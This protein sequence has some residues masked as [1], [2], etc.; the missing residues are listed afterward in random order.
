M[1]FVKP[2][3]VFPRIAL[4]LALAGLSCATPSPEPTKPVASADIQ[5]FAA[6]DAVAQAAV[7]QARLVELGTWVA[8][9]IE[10]PRYRVPYSQT[11]LWHGAEQG[12]LVT[13]V[14]FLDYQCP[15]SQRLGEAL[16]Q[17]VETYPHELRVVVKQLPLAKMHPR[18]QIA[19]QAVLA[20][21]AQG[22][23]WAMHERVFVSQDALS[24]EDLMRHARQA[25]VAD[26]P[27]FWADVEQAAASSTIEADLTLADQLGVTSTPSYFVNGV[28]HRGAKTFLELRE[29]YVA[30]RDRVEGL[31]E[32]GA[33]DDEVYAALMLD[34]EATREP[35]KRA[36]TAPK[37]GKPDPSLS[38]A[39]PVDHR[40]TRGRDDALVTIIEFADFDCPYSRRVQPTLKELERRYGADL[41][42]VYRHQPLPMHT[43]AK[44]AAHAAMAAD[45]QGQFWAMH[46]AMFGR[47]D[48]IKS[49]DFFALAAD[50]G[51]DAKRFRT[52]MAS[53]A[54]AKL[55]EQDQAVAAN[56]GASGTPA[57]FI[58]GR[59]LMGAQPIDAFVH[60]ID[61]ELAKAQ[62]YQQQ[63]HVAG[64]DLYT[65]MA[66][67]WETK[68]EKPPVADRERR[69]LS[70]IGH[71]GKGTLRSPKLTILGCADFDCPYSARGAA[72]IDEV[73]AT[74]RYKGKVG[75]YFVNFPLPMH[76][77][78]QIAHQAAVAAD[79]QGKFWPMHD[80][81]FA[82]KERRSEAELIEMATQ[83]GLD[84]DQFTA[85]LYSQKTLDKIVADKQLCAAHGITGTPSYF[86]NGRL[87]RGAVPIEMAS[88]VL[89]EELAGGFENAKSKSN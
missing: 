72:M 53:S 85:D 88:Q 71:P 22:R 73:L 63:H 89:D 36:P 7:D 30:E 44:E 31:L 17:L 40:P 56:F 41:R 4:A 38:Y 3:A 69:E 33:R 37:P 57:F 46:D 14:V 19:A 65:K 15:Y 2:L 61:E 59:P 82:N 6:V 54:V 18:A 43:R 86:V 60:V 25:G 26:L 47:D 10:G 74:K 32:A 80:M 23:G 84:I 87:M 9:N 76:K 49:A 51:L 77:D 50:L 5:V 35:P 27:R 79:N 39:V 64:N 70:V 29:L 16:D 48:G 75:Y 68:V 12:P 20:A 11:D 45:R 8:A 28:P 55:I 62:A 42:L 24:D 21:H 13:I 1:T 58:N 34:A 81:L 66:R 78:A 83:L 67:D 52:D